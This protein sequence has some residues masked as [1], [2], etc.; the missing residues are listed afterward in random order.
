MKKKTTRVSTEE[1]IDQPKMRTVMIASPSY[2]GKVNVWHAS[3][4][5]ETCKIGLTKGINVICVY[6]SYDALV[7]RARNDIFKLALNSKVDDLFFID[8]DVDW[9]PNDFFR[10]LDHD[11]AVVAAPVV[12]KSDMEQYGVKIAEKFNIEDNGLAIVDGIGTAFMRIRSD[13]IQKVWDASVEYRES[14]KEQPIR[15]VFEVRI[16]NGMLQ[17]EDISFCEKVVEVGE[18]V[19]VDPIVVC[20]HSG[21]K[22]WIGNFYQWIKL[23]S[24]RS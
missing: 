18:K 23:F 6:M 12:K 14:H 15:M 3:A 2:D 1:T 17:S 19:Y 13:I 10:M 24:N 7:Q 16:A 5:S 9:N 4:L 22:R 8:C 21:E 11:V 20:G